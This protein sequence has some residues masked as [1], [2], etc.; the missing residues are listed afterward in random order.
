MLAL[1]ALVFAALLAQQVSALTA[2]DLLF[3]RQDNPDD[4]I[5]AECETPCT[6]PV[7]AI[8]TCTSVECLCN[9]QIAQELATC[10]SCVVSV[11]GPPTPADLTQAQ[12]SLN[13]APKIH[14]Y[15]FASDIQALLVA[16]ED[17]CAQASAPVSS[18]TVSST[19][20]SVTGTGTVV[21]SLAS[22]TPSDSGT[23]SVF[24]S[25][26]A[27]ASASAGAS[28]ASNTAA[29]A[30]N[31]AATNTAS[32][33]SSTNPAQGS[34]TAAT[35]SGSGALNP[36]NVSGAQVAFGGLSRLSVVAAGVLCGAA[37]LFNL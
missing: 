25:S 24:F 17:Q 23:P 28:A 13:G 19:S 5:P 9:N 36:T 14:T 2:R 4:V 26:N 11:D 6:D 3:L 18:L 8:N 37:A 34:N 16:F 1:S 12:D 35:S 21:F 7:N 15:L 22:P 20:L 31:S 32:G 29:S 27:G 10:F 33:G 30:A